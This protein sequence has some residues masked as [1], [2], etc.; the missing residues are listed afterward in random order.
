MT[1]L[2]LRL[3]RTG[4]ERLIRGGV[5]VTTP[6]AIFRIHG[7]G[8]LDCLQG[9]LTNDLAA[10]GPGHMVYAAMLTPKGMIVVDFW[11]MIGTDEVVLIG[12]AEGHSVA[13]EAFRRSFPPRLASV[14]DMSDSW[15]ALWLYGDLA[16]PALTAAHLTP[17][18]GGPGRMAPF[19]I[20]G[21]EVWVASATDSAPFASLV[22]GPRETIEHYSDLLTEH[23]VAIGTPDDYHA[24]R[25]MAGWPALGIEIG[26]KTLPQEVRFEAI[27]GVSFTKGCFIGQETVARVHFRGKTQK[28]LRGLD[29]IDLGP[30]DGTDIAD[31][32]RALGR[33]HSVL[34]L[35][36]RRIGLGMV[37]REA[38]IGDTVI[39][40]GR[41]ATIAPL[42]FDHPDHAA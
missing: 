3:D 19:D 7:P 22:V 6:A 34:V 9:V 18:L 27:E 24:A 32:D 2:S 15:H 21:S 31:K 25:I 16:E 4:V 30:L 39:A 41:E 12:P 42:P 10:P 29:W 36:D 8:A 13:A 40:G 23:G 28:E 38:D 33:V 20:L 11:V 26:E 37:R 17:P 5:S 1:T 35:P 14:E